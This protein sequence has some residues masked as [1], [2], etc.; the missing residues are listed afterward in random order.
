MINNAYKQSFMPPQ[1]MAY[2]YQQRDCQ[3][4]VPAESSEHEAKLW[5]ADH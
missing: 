1:R 3:A 5:S 2:L 4:F